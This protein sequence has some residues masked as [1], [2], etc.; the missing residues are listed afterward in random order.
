M[1]LLELLWKLE[2]VCM[3]GHIGHLPLDGTEYVG[4]RKVLLWLNHAKIDILLV[5]SSNLLLLLLKSF[6]LRSK[7]KL[8]H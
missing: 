2:S 8:F 7:S 3:W 5:G 6:N 4:S 1:L